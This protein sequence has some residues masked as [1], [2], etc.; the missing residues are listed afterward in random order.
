MTE[1][2]GLTV[3]QLEII[4]ISTVIGRT[5]A[6]LEIQYGVSFTN[7]RTLGPITQVV[8]VS[9]AMTFAQVLAFRDEVV[10]PMLAKELGAGLQI[11][12]MQIPAG[13]LQ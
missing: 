5:S 12:A 3:A 4:S 11:T 13:I 2:N 1:L 8:P 9:D 7:G 6:A 10:I